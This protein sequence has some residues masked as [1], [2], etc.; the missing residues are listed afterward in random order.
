MKILVLFV[1]AAVICSFGLIYLHELNHQRIFEAWGIQSSIHIGFPDWY[2]S[3]DNY[4]N[5]CDSTCNLAHTI[6]DSVGYNIQAPFVL[7]VLG[8]FCL[9]WA[10]EERKWKQEDKDARQECNSNNKPE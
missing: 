4:T 7:F 5:G 6:N 3:P 8:M 1:I 2:V 10:I 9:L